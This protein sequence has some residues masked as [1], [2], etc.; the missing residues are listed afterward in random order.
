VIAC[1][2]NTEIQGT[3]FAVVTV[4]RVELTDGLTVF[5]N[6]NI[7]RAVVVV[8]AVRVGSAWADRAWDGLVNATQRQV[9]GVNCTVLAV[10]TT[11]LRVLA[12]SSRCAHI[13][14][15]RIG[16]R[17]DNGCISTARAWITEVVC[18]VITVITADRIVIATD[19]RIASINGARVVIITGY[20]CIDASF[21]RI[22][23]VD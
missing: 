18:T 12:A 13:I 10:I 11:L 6:T 23:Y 4:Q 5:D 7:G 16:V 20:G 3:G 15:T 21:I 22:A 1:A 2:V 19:D 17:A 14:G 8:V 9:A